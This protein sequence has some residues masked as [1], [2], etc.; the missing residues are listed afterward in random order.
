MKVDYFTI[1]EITVTY[2]DTVKTS[3]RAV[4][5]CPADGAR[6]FEEACKECMEHHEEVYV[7]FLNRANRVLGI[8]NVSK[9][10]ISSSVTDVRIIL[11]TALKVSAS[12]IMLGHNHPS[13]NT[14]PSG[15]DVAMTK[16]VQKGCEAIGIQLLDHVI[17]TAEGYTSFADSGLL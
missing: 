11:Q 6:I 8:S 1:P 3:Q 13:G 16:E 7:L 9:G 14:K 15:Q 17:M 4:V 10:G 12:S 2:K 5:T